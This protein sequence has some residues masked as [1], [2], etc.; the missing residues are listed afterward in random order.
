[1]RGKGRAAAGA[2]AMS[3]ARMNQE[4]YGTVTRTA[5]QVKDLQEM[6]T[7]ALKIFEEYCWTV[8][9]VCRVSERP[10]PGI[11][12][13]PAAK[14]PRIT[15]VLQRTN[16]ELKEAWWSFCETELQGIKDPNRHPEEV[17]QTPPVSVAQTRFK[18]GQRE[19]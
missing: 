4:R 8:G 12:A 14:R 16:P 18:L 1:M 11:V 17:L 9:R 13:A 2:R 7:F 5:I 19:L 6:K 15:Q 10:L 3:F